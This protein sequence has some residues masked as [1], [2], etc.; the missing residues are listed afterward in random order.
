[1]T[2]SHLKVHDTAVA[3]AKSGQEQQ[4]VDVNFLSS[5]LMAVVSMF[6]NILL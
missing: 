3:G 1:M 5:R 2:F 6:R 4:H